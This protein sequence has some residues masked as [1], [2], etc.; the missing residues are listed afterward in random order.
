[1]T[2]LMTNNVYGDFIKSIRE[3]DTPKPIS[4]GFLLLDNVGLGSGLYNGLYVLG[5]TSGLGKTTFALQIANHIASHENRKVIYYALEMSANEL[6]AKSLSGIA[7]S[8]TED[9][10]TYNPIQNIAKKGQHSDLP[11]TARNIMRGHIKENFSEENKKKLRTAMAYYNS[12]SENMIISSPLTKRPSVDEIV[13]EVTDYVQTT[14]NKPVV[15]VDYLQLLRPVEGNHG[16]TDKQAVTAAVN[17]LKLLSLS[18]KIPVFVISSFNRSSYSSIDVDETAFK[19]S[20]DIEYTADV[21]FI[22]ENDFNRVWINDISSGRDLNL[23]DYEQEKAI[24]Q[25]RD[26]PEKE[27]KQITIDEAIKNHRVTIPSAMRYVKLLPEKAIKLSILKNRFG[28]MLPPKMP[29]IP[30]ILN[31]PY[32]VFGQTTIEGDKVKYNIDPLDDY[33]YED[34]PIYT[35]PDTHEEEF[36]I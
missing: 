31:A 29:Y 23:V 33:S 6:I 15:F 27:G 34:M 25:N 32:S 35:N 1:M 16:Y 7:W 5:A 22:M 14:K 11:L 13:K 4:T 30:F 26:F 28:D 2:N 21:V 12:F 9:H 10:D 3:E 20:G 17:K 36:E 19:E 8:L 24:E 18:L